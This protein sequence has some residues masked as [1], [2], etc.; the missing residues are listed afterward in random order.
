MSAIGGVLVHRAGLGAL[1]LA[2]GLLDRMAHRAPDG[3][4]FHDDRDLALAQGALRATPEASWNPQPVFVGDW[5]VVVD[6]RVDDRVGLFARLQLGRDDGRPDEALFA[7]AWREW[8]VDLGLHVVGDFA[9]AAWH[10]P[11][12]TLWLIRDRVG[13]RPLY[14]VRNAQLFGF[15][16][17]AEALLSLPA[18]SS[19][20]DSDRVRYYL[21]P[22]LGDGD[23]SGSWYRDVHK[24]RPGQWLKVAAEGKVE[25][26]R[27]WR[28]E[29]LE[30]LRL[31]DRAE[32]QQAFREVFGE[33]VRCR[34]RAPA[35]PALMLS[36]GIDSAAVLAMLR[37]GRPRHEM[38]CQLVSV[39]SDLADQ[40]P[41]TANILQMHRG[42]RDT[43]RLPVPS[44]AGPLGS[45]D[46]APLPWSPAHP[47]DNALLLPMLVYRAVQAMGGRVVL[48]GMDGDLVMWSRADRAARLALGGDWRN[49]WREARL[50]SQN[51][52]YLQGLPAG[53]MLARGLLSRLQPAPVFALRQACLVHSRKALGPWLSSHQVRTGQ[54]RKRLWRRRVDRHRATAGLTHT[55]GL[56]YA[57]EHGGLFRAMEG[58]DHLAARF[59][60][61]PR[62]PWSDQRVLDFFLRLPEEQV[63]ADGWTKHIARA[64]CEPWLGCQVAWHSGKSHLGHQLAGAAVD[65]ASDRLAQ[66]LG[67]DGVLAAWVERDALAQVRHSVL[68]GRG[69]LPA[70]ELGSLAAWMEALE[71]PT[72]GFDLG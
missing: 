15:A 54:L 38:A 50:S 26:G 4:Q 52:T 14:W 53:R 71:R 18:V 70:V 63:T 72:D 56:A 66:W 31:R 11:S 55:E 30:P 5:V 22:A 57:W 24:L 36:G 45:V 49:G 21:A 61:E 9:L 68:A 67:E 69:G 64:A 19:A 17:E 33:A 42:E 46:F 37:R 39:V 10:T 44:F 62:H 2:R 60:I 13:V 28:P 29:P 20:P 43:V 40:C 34:L 35:T 7:G 8:G 3:R 59:G 16:S 27:W 41:E 48:D 25:T 23:P 6:G 32:Y 47:V 12:R 1:P 58:M 51:H 65:C